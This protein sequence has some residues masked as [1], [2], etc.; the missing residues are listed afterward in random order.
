MRYKNT[1]HADIIYMKH[2]RKYHAFILQRKYKHQYH[3]D[4]SLD[5]IVNIN[6]MQLFPR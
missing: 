6:I 5:E 3:A 1:Y 4:T 2:K